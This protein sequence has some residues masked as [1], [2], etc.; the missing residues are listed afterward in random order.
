ME[1]KMQIH[2]LEGTPGGGKTTRMIETIVS[3]LQEGVDPTDILVL[4]FTKRAQQEAM[5]RISKETGIPEDKLTNVRTIHS[6][7]MAQLGIKKDQVIND[8]HLY[9][10]GQENG[11]LFP[12]VDNDALETDIGSKRINYSNTYVNMLRVIQL[13]RA[14]KF[15]NWDQFAERF[16]YMLRGM[17]KNEIIKMGKL[18]KQWRRNHSLFDFQDMLDLFEGPAKYPRFVFVDEGQ[19]LTA[20]QWRVI[21]LIIDHAESL[22]VYRDANQAIYSW[23]GAD[24]FFFEKIFNM[25]DVDHGFIDMSYRCA[26][27]IGEVA[28]QVLRRMGSAINA[29]WSC[30]KDGG[31]IEKRYFENAIRAGLLESDDVLIIA[32][33]NAYVSEYITGVRSRGLTY[34]RGDVDCRE[35]PTVAAMVALQRLKNGEEIYQRELRRIKRY[36]SW[37]INIPDSRERPMS[38]QEALPGY[39][40]DFSDILDML[41]SHDKAYHRSIILHKTDLTVKPHIRVSTIHASKGAQAKTVMLDTRG[42]PRTLN[43]SR[44]SSSFDDEARVWYV[45]ASRAMNHLMMVRPGQRGMKLS[46]MSYSYGI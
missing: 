28:K 31:I 9:Q 18:W 25:R 16:P 46:Q 4:T 5:R 6:Y 21:N 8:A 42:T 39:N 45:A 20:S 1:D 37:K 3:L 26:N 27:A 22:Y 44:G 19:D 41:P 23:G 30:V 35:Y 32:R 7:T 13:I 34:I 43:H 38:L 10:F 36:S 33:T 15:S 2:L 40:G 17:D 12:K 11:Y 14:T 24:A 29:D